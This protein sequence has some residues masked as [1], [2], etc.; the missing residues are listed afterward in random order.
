[1]SSQKKSYEVIVKFVWKPYSRPTIIWRHWYERRTTVY[2]RTAVQTPEEAYNDNLMNHYAMLTITV[3]IMVLLWGSVFLSSKS[4][5]TMT[6]RNAV[7]TIPGAFP[8]KEKAKKKV[9]FCS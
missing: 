9:L 3:G 7:P 2:I 4:L 5:V 1:M 8:R 6:R